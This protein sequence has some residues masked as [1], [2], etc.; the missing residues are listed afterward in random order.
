MADPIYSRRMGDRKDGRQ[1][2]SLP[3]SHRLIPYFEKSRSAST[4]SYSDSVEITDLEKYIRKKRSEDC[5]EL[6]ILHVFIAAYVRTVALCPGINRYISG[7]RI[8][9][10]TK[11]TVITQ[12]KRPSAT[13]ESSDALIKIPLSSIDSMSEIYRKFN[14]K[15]M[16][17]K[18]GDSDLGIETLVSPL[19]RLPGPISKLMFWFFNLADY[20]G[21][22]PVNFQELSPYHG[23]LMITDLASLGIKPVTYNLNDFGNLSFKI[24]FGAKRKQVELI[25][26]DQAPKAV[27]QQYVDFTINMDERICDQNYYSTAFKY[28]KHYLRH[29]E[30]LDKAPESTAEDIF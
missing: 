1:L 15:T 18:T 26:R 5:P 28:L 10:R 27:L 30:L 3:A 8:Y 6:S 29:P 9:A 7:Q 23:S 13:G 12:V 4:I 16:R 19:V 25:E 22:L 11:I 2:R 20:F 17:L 14:D 24:S 21:L